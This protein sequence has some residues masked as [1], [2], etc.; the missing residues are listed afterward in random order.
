MKR[1]LVYFMVFF[2]SVALL[3]M[4]NGCAGLSQAEGPGVMK[5]DD[6]GSGTM[7]AQPDGATVDDQND[8]RTAAAQAYNSGEEGNSLADAKG[9]K[10]TATSTNVGDQGQAK[11]T[12][13]DPF[14]EAKLNYSYSNEGAQ[15]RTVNASE[16]TAEGKTMEKV[17]EKGGT[18]SAKAT[19]ERPNGSKAVAADRVFNLEKLGGMR[20]RVKEVDNW[21]NQT[22]SNV[23]PH[24]A[25]VRSEIEGGPDG[26]EHK[27]VEFF[28]LNQGTI[29]FECTP[30]ENNFVYGLWA[31]E[32]LGPHAYN[33]MQVGALRSLIKG[34]TTQGDWVLGGYFYLTD[35]LEET[36][37][38]IAVAEN[39][40]DSKQDRL[41]REKSNYQEIMDRLGDP[42]TE[43]APQPESQSGARGEATTTERQK[44][45]IDQ[46]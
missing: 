32:S 12:A 21:A 30:A 13:Q 43:V 2:V 36:D 18:T 14:G 10:A 15:A 9:W 28:R 1:N 19:N 6:V 31:V 11:A 20:F 45:V 29:L 5:G 41:Q 24:I 42:M 46:K 33:P 4:L 39:P 26:V 27:G 35:M 3:A 8:R 25:P 37:S 38:P 17:T 22:N 7:T 23:H 44:E 34:K 40:F 16:Q